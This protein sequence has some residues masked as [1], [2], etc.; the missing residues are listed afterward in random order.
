MTL[1]TAAAIFVAGIAAGF[2]NTLAGGGSLLTLPALMLAGLPADIANG[3]NRLA[4]VT[5]SFS[6]A[7]GFARR[8]RLDRRQLVPVVA[9]TVVG[10]VLGAAVASQVPEAV[11][12]P[13]LLGVLVTMATVL[14]F[15]PKLVTGAEGGTP[16]Q[17]LERPA[18][19][20]GLFL[21]GAYGGFIQAGVGFVLL[22]VLGGVLRYDLVGA[23]ALKLVC[24]TVFGLAALL[25]FV[26][27]GQVVWGP[28]A[29]LAVATVLGSQLGV[30]F[31]VSVPQ[32]RLRKILLVCVIAACIGVLL[33]G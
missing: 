12:R 30:R 32:D 10:A 31:A 27:A 33:K 26:A 20:V 1:L 23:N 11:L 29:L 17:V 4:I 22:A 13:V 8:G 9:P 3:T 24:T 16:E 21:A 5:Q 14:A 6:G 19:M 25:V 18:G 2:V 7:T 28:A 15:R